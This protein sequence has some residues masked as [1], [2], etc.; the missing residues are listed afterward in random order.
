MHKSSL[1]IRTLFFLILIFSLTACENVEKKNEIVSEPVAAKANDTEASPAEVVKS[2]ENTVDKKDT[3]K[4]PVAARVNGIEISRVDF[5][6]ALMA[7]QQ[8]FASIGA[9]QGSTPDDVNIEK[10]VMN[11][12]VDIELMLQ[13]AKQRG[14]T[15]ENV[16]VDGRMAGFRNS[17][18]TEKEFTDYLSK[19]KINTEIVKEQITKQMTLQQLQRELLQEMKKNIKITQE[20]SRSFYDANLERFKYPEQIKASHILITVKEDADEVTAKQALATAEALRKKAVDG[21]DFAELAKNNSQGPSSN[22]GGDL[23]FFGKGQMVKSFEEAAFSLKP[24]EIS[25]VVKTKFG[26]HI[27]KVAE[28]KAAG[29]TPFEEMEEKI[30]GYLSQTQLDEAQVQYTKELREKAKIEVNI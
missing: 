18:K 6:N 15:V 22:Q 3:S 26:Y 16:A 21:E 8:Q 25:E 7:A 4:D 5:D 29:V 24:G 20:E 28:T 9:G 1:K 2:P 19:N 17:F 10:E 30:S 27:I 13:D 23:G 14:V 12:L 11:R